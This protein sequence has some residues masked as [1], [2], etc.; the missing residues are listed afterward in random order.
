MNLNIYKIVLRDKRK[1]ILRAQQYRREDDQYVFETEGD[2]E[3][4][5]FVAEEV[6]GVYLMPPDA[7]NSRGGGS[8]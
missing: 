6:I 8:Y 1:E 5:F 3:V 2:A 4:Q 7:F